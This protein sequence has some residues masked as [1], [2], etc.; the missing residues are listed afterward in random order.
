MSREICSI[1]ENNGT[2]NCYLTDQFGIPL[3]VNEGIECAEVDP[4]RRRDVNVTLPSG[5]VTTLQEV[6]LFKR[7]FIV[8]EAF[9]NEARRSL[10]NG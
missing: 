2:V 9:D 10:Y 6:T 1:I 3:P 8:I 4:N 7:G 5:E